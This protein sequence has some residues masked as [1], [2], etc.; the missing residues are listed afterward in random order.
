[1]KVSKP[2]NMTP[3]ATA[4]MAAVIRSTP[5]QPMSGRVAGV[6][7][8][9]VREVRAVCVGSVVGRWVVIAVVLLPWNPCGWMPRGGG[10]PSYEPACAGAHEGYGE[11]TAE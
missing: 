3:K 10:H 11:R 8:G 4:S 7:A 9:G 1:M 2:Q 6:V 5:R